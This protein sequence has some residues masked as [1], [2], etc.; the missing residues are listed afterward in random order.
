MK[1]EKVT[2]GGTVFELEGKGVE[3][4]HKAPDFTLPDKD[5]KPVSLKNFKGKTVILSTVP[6]LDTPTC[7][8]ETRRFNKEAS[9]LGDKVV[10]LTVSKDLPF[11]QAR[12][13]A[14]AGIDRVITLSDYQNGSF[15]KDYGVLMKGI[16]LLTRAIF[17]IDAKGAVQ[18]I[19]YVPEVSK[20]PE[21]K[22]V[23]DA[24]KKLI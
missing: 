19:Q 15:A 2:L 8:V 13:C 18:Y 7:N 14:A 3:I 1:P 12:W 16:F 22:E 5:M 6:S 21:Y 11:A 17:V 4:G 20:E 10:V 9:S 23:L 24:V